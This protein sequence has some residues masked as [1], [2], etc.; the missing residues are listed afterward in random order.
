[1]KRVTFI[2]GGA[3]SGKSHYAET[4]ARRAKKRTYIAT[5]EAIDEEMRDRIATHR[6]RRGEDWTTCEAPLDLVTALHDADEAGSLVVIDC[7]TVWI[8][9]LMHYGR[10][11]CE[12]VERLCEML[13][14]TAGEVIIVANEVGLGIVPD[15]APARRFRDEAGRANQKIAAI[16]DEVIFMSAGLPLVLKKRSRSRSLRKSKA[17][18]RARKA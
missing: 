9:N 4:L 15:N 6:D 16:A 5:A 12:E 14:S 11:V 13:L 1:M 3:R 7:I 2:L 18:A 8:G 17:S 10:P